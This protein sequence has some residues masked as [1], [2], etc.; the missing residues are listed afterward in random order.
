MQENNNNSA[1]LN[2]LFTLFSQLNSDDEQRIEDVYFDLKEFLNKP[3]YYRLLATK[4]VWSCDTHTSQQYG[5]HQ[6]HNQLYD[7]P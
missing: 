1:E 6:R 3:G 5:V 4:E 7:Q 2:K